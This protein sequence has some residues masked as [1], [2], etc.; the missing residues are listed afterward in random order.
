MKFAIRDMLFTQ[1]HLDT[2]ES[3]PIEFFETWAVDYPDGLFEKVCSALASKPTLTT[4]RIHTLF[5]TYVQANALIDLLSSNL[6][7]I[8]VTLPYISDV[9]LAPYFAQLPSI[10][11]LTLSYSGGNCG[12]VNSVIQNMRKNDTLRSLAIPAAWVSESTMRI[13]SDMLD[14]NNSLEAFY[15][16]SFD[17]SAYAEAIDRKLKNNTRYNQFRDTTLFN[18][19]VPLIADQED[20]HEEKK[21]EEHEVRDVKRQRLE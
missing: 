16:L 12:F 15:T 8:D 14:E 20:E 9:I 5:L 7:I 3:N 1:E 21:E 6:S 11:K 13:L 17:E 19:L 2:I 4:L 18:K 10:E